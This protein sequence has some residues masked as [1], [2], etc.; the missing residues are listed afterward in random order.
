MQDDFEWEVRHPS[1]PFYVH[2]IGTFASNSAGSC[3]GISEHLFMLPFDNIKVIVVASLDPLPSRPVSFDKGDSTK[4][5]QKGRSPKLLQW[6]NSISS[7]LHSSSWA[8]L[9]Y[10]RVHDGETGTHSSPPQQQ[11]PIYD[12]WVYFLTLSRLN[13]H[14]DRSDQAAPAVVPVRSVERSGL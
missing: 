3:A 9:Q 5:I 6:L 11:L 10:L 7:R 12:R 14:T 13:P 2:L 1:V 4:D 8:L